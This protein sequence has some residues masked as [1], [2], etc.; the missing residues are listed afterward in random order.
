MSSQENLPVNPISPAPSGGKLKP[1]IHPMVAMA[2]AAVIALSATGIAAFSGVLQ[3]KPA[4]AGAPLPLAAN[5]AN[6]AASSGTADPA[7]AALA[8]AGAGQAGSKASVGSV[9]ARPDAKR[10]A[11]ASAPVDA[12]AGVI[13][14][15]R[16]IKHTP[17]TSGVGAVAGG[18]VGGVVGNQIGGGNGKT[19]M[20]VLGAVGGGVLGNHIEKQQKTTT[21][22]QVSVRMDNGT[23]RTV[24]LSQV[25]GWQVGE[26]V[27]LQQGQLVGMRNSAPRSAPTDATS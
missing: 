10:T 15:I 9:G 19:A 22:Y 17:P 8:P 23:R 16:P 12:S 11:Q 26:R 1:T 4:N 21:S 3:T 14:S 25:G 13:E 2:C 24:S 20:T 27:R 18:V 7:A 5:A 6:T